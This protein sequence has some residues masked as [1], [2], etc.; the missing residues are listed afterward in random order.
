MEDLYAGTKLGVPSLPIPSLEDTTKRYLETVRHLAL[1]D[2]EYDATERAAFELLSSN[3]GKEL[4]QR[5][6]RVAN[7]GGEGGVYPYSYIEGWWDEMYQAGRLPA[8]VNSYPF[9]I[10]NAPTASQTDQAA[11]FAHALFGW[12]QDVRSG[13][14][15]QDKDPR[16]NPMC[17][18]QYARVLGATQVPRKDRDIIHLAPDAQHIVV[19]HRHKYYRVEMGGGASKKA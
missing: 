2:A 12:W 6:E 1:D 4:Q 8:V 7:E 13:K 16:G 11:S 19:L 5:V 15:A 18:F 3:V 17:M 10:I 9:Y 14:L